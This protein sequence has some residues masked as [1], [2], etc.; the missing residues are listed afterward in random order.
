MPANDER[1]AK[2]R[3][4]AHIVG[5][6]TDVTNFAAVRCFA[7]SPKRAEEIVANLLERGEL[8][9]LK[10]DGGDNEPPYVCTADRDRGDHPCIDIVIKHGSVLPAPFKL[11][12]PFC[13][14]DGSEESPHGGTF[15]YLSHQ[16]T[17]REI[18]KFIRAKK[19]HGARLIVE[20]RSEVYD[21]DEEINERIEC[22][23]CLQEFPFPKSLQ[24]DFI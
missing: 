6:A 3:M 15:R 9:T 21:E 5:V 4:R 2:P 20:G 13:D 23:S 1:K 19:G 22:R 7:E 12:C 18:T 24:I 14:Y 17:H 8:S 10:Y 11:K 16:T